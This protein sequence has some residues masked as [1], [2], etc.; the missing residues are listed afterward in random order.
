MSIAQQCDAWRWEKVRIK[1]SLQE[2]SH[3]LA[4]SGATNGWVKCPPLSWKHWNMKPFQWAAAV[5]R[6]LRLDVI[7]APRTCSFCHWQLC[8]TKGYLSIMCKGGP[9]RILRHNEI[10]DTLSKA[11]KRAGFSIGLEHGGGLSDGR[12]PGDII[13]YNWERGKHL[14]ID[15]GITNPTRCP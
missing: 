4:H 6:R 5:R 1:L 3:L 15:V 9:S 11:I 12:K 7:A 13:I 10:R 8:D 2:K 14:L